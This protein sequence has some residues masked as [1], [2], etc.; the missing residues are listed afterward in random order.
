MK[1]TLQLIALSLSLSTYA[2]KE[3]YASFALKTDVRNAV[4]GS[5]PTN[6]N[7]ALDI[8]ASVN[9]VSNNFEISF[10]DEYFQRIGFNST[11]VNFGYHFP[12]YISLGAK[13][14]DITVIPYAGFSLITRF[15]KEDKEIITPEQ[16]F[17]VYGKSAHISAQAGLS[18]RVKLSDKFLLDWTCEAMARPDLSYLY[19]TDPNKA[20][21]VSNYV[22]V[23]Y[24]FSN[25]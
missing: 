13:E 6:N 4:L 3:T 7:P 22:G 19:P 17:Y 8:T 25:F 9:M 23:H 12:R 1:K 21:V 2:Q 24:I 5:K 15:G 16:D 18:F 10:G 14:I 11:F 20:V